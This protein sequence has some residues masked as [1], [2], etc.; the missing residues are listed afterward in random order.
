[1]EHIRVLRFYY[2]IE[3]ESAEAGRS[4]EGVGGTSGMSEVPLRGS[5]AD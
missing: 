2:G 4:P 1:M 3:W 5:P